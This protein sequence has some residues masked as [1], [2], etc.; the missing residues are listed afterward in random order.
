[1]VHFY[2]KRGT[3]ERW[4]KEGKKAMK[5]TWLI[6]DHFRS[7]EVRIWPSPLAYNL[8]SLWR[9]VL[10]KRTNHGSLTSW[11]LRLLKTGGCLIK[12]A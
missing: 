9:L 3:A 2:N 4:I 7:N 5:M 10:P 12:R 1:M 11:Q 8:G 6:C